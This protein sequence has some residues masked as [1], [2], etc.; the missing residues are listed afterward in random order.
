MD[1]I[2][3][4]AL[5]LVPL[6][7]FLFFSISPSLGE[8]ELGGGRISLIQG[9]VFLQTGDEGEWTEVSLNFPIADGDRLV[10]E[11]DGK[12]ELHLKDGTY[13][14]MGEGTTLDILTLSFVRTKSLIHLNLSEGRIYVN[15]HSISG[16]VPPLYIDLPYGVLSSHIPTR[17]KVDLT[18]SEAKISVLQGS[19]EWRGEGRPIPLTQGKTLIARAEGHTVIGGIYGKDEWDLWNEARDN[20]IFNRRYAQKY[21]PPELEPWGYEIEPYGRWVYVQEYQYVW[22]PIV[23]V[24][25]APFRHGHWTWRK[26]V[27]CWVPR[28]PWGW[29]PFHYGRWIYLPHHGWVWVP[30]VPRVIFWHPGAVAWHIG[31][32]YVSWVP[33]APGEIYYGYRY[34]GP[35]SVNLNRP[36]LSIPRNIFVNAKVKDAVVT[37][38]KDSFFKKHPVAKIEI[39]ENPFLNPGK[40]SGPPVEK[41]LPQDKVKTPS[42]V[43]KEF[44]KVPKTE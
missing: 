30:P 38:P 25:W 11:W 5:S 31:P 37:L 39:K 27:Y 28:E 16:E 12:V 43:L 36:N 23:S 35:Y 26:G 13:V 9:Q 20:E 42:R 1:K 3:G 40:I 21:L 14:R 10:T 22:V 4:F 17:F 6:L 41:P 29:V 18:P 34:Y 19:L 44:P 33:L 24:G 15:R 2:K 7:L 8:N 32:N